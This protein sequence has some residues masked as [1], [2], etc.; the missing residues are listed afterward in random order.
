MLIS[1]LRLLTSVMDAF[2]DFNYL[3]LVDLLNLKWDG[4]GN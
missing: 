2:N 4:G 3:T 1:D